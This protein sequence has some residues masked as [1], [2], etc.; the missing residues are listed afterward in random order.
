MSHLTPRQREALEVIV[1]FHLEHGYAP[2]LTEIGQRMGISAKSTVLALLWY[3]RD[4][5]C[6]TW[7]PNSERTLVVTPEGRELLGLSS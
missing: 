2:T 7:V 4:A 5:G 3:G 1:A 6:V